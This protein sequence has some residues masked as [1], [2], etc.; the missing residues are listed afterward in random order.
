MGVLGI[1]IGVGCAAAGLISG[2]HIEPRL[3]PIGALG[4]IVFFLL[5]A[6]V[7]PQLANQEG[8]MRIAMSNVALFILGAG[9]FAGFYIIPL[10]ALLQKLS[11]DD[12]R[13]RFLGTANAV[14]FAFMTVSAL[15]FAAV[16]PAFG[17]QPQK[18]FYLCA[19]LMAAGAAYFL[20]HLRGTGILIGSPASSPTSQASADANE[21]AEA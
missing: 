6:T 10:Q 15:F 7:T 1:A 3:I 8:V 16:R 9:F 21:T 12:E 11:P 20:W 2:H 14:S 18:I 13:G 5:L 19:L 4:L 17:N